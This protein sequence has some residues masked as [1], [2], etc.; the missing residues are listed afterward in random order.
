MNDYEIRK[1]EKIERYREL[2]R[3]AEKQQS[4]L[5]EESRK[6]SDAIP[7]GQ[8]ILIGHHSE[9]RDRR[10]RERISNKADQAMKA[11]DH[12]EY[13]NRKADALEN[14]ISINTGDSEAVVKMREKIKAA[15]ELQ[16]RYKAINV[17]IRKG[18][19]DRAAQENAL[20]ELGYCES[21]IDS[22]LELDFSGRV[23][24]ARYK[25]TNNGANIRRMEKRLAK[26]QKLG[27]ME[28]SERT[29]NGVRIVINAEENR[30]Q[31]FFPEKPSEEVRGFMK[32]HGFHFAP[33]WDGKPWQR[34]YS[35][36]AVELANQ[37][38]KINGDN[39]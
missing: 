16:D 14:N 26:L 12:A 15:Q 13:W 22:L 24:I 5:W 33:S 38:I 20:S 37:A 7:F 2:A 32:M 9:G 18:K 25:L 36:S 35:L 17:A 10:Y 27:E 4:A 3:N 29:V 6:M 30:V 1:Q 28:T 8:P 23:G 34:A 31:I 19:G 11:G 39:K 21:V